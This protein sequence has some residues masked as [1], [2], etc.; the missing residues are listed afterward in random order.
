MKPRMKDIAESLG[1]SRT[2]VSLVLKGAGDK[3]NISKKTQQRILHKV[4][5]LNYRPNYFAS[6]L[7]LKRSGIIGVILPNVFEVYMNEII[8][9]IEDILY[10]N[11][12]NMMLCTSRFSPE[13]EKR[14]IDHLKPIVDGFL[15]AFNAPFADT[16]YDYSHLQQLTQEQNPVVFIDRYLPELKSAYVVQD[17]FYG[18]FKAVECLLKKGCRRIGYISFNLDITSIHERFRGYRQALKDQQ[19]TYNPDHTIL[20]H[21]QNDQSGDL[22]AAMEHVFR[23][24]ERP[25]AFFVTTNGIALKAGSLLKKMGHRVPMARFGMDPDYFSSKMILV[26]QPHMA[27]GKQAA[28]MLLDQISGQSGTAGKE[29]QQRIKPGI[30]DKITHS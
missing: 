22:Q 23:L 7:N 13:I 26:E 21:Q 25:D 24:K 30:I 10:K 27:I 19:V 16:P 12:Y 11:S 5:E 14:N 9:G 29:M 6:A 18:A 20:L 3:Y 4:K 2:T 15:I 8:H 28:Q 17:D 1:L